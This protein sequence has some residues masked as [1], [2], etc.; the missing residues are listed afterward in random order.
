M[1]HVLPEWLRIGYLYL[2]TQTSNKYDSIIYSLDITQKHLRRVSKT[3][4]SNKNN[5]KTKN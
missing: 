2:F 3:L 5:L 1:I 4:P